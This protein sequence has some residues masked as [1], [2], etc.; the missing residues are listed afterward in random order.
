MA[1]LPA[2]GQ[3]I[4]AQS[5]P[6]AQV[7]P[8]ADP[9]NGFPA[10]TRGSGHGQ[11]P[12]RNDVFSSTA[13]ETDGMS[14]TDEIALGRAAYPHLVAKAG[15][16]HP[17]QRLQAALREFFRPMIAV[18]DR[19]HLPWDV[20]LV[21]ERSTNAGA[22]PGGKVLVNVGL[23]SICDRAGELAATLAH[24]IGHV[25]KRHGARRQ[26]LND[27]I[28]SLRKDGVASAVPLETLLPQSQG[29]LEDVWEL[30]GKAYSREDEAEADGHEMV[31]LERLGVDPIHAVNDQRNFA[32][33]NRMMGDPSLNELAS[34]HPRDENRMA[35]IQQLA[36]SQRRPK[37]DY[38]FP[39]WPLLKAAFPTAPQFKKA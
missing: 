39:G 24:E 29:Q 14:E 12:P 13:S 16:A 3:A 7:D 38:V 6:W 15:G 26:P 37:T 21:N 31:I 22:L 30:F 9:R 8:Y 17:D 11:T 5:D 35:H 36:A 32:M 10:E 27:L 18:S 2:W 34:T 19:P 28:A 33:I 1:A 23:I 20:T 4:G 25:D